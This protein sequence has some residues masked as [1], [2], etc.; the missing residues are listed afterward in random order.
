MKNKGRLKNCATVSPVLDMPL[1]YAEEQIYTSFPIYNV[2]I[3]CVYKDAPTAILLR[4]EE[5]FALKTSHC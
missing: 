5:R 3:I 4:Q 2:R 1:R